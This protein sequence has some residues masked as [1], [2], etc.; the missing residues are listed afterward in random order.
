MIID[1][2]HFYLTDKEGRVRVYPSNTKIFELGVNE[3]RIVNLIFPRE[4]EDPVI[5]YD[6]NISIIKVP[7]FSISLMIVSIGIGISIYLLRE[8][9]NKRRKF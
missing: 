5:V 6:D 4:Y 7:E 8:V 9:H 3:S 2:K 1:L